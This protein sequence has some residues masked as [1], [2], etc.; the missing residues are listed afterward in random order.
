MTALAAAPDTALRR[1]AVRAVLAPSVHNTQPWRLRLTE[2]RLELHADRARQL[3]V[4]DPT[5]RQLLV[6]CGCALM[7]AR[8]A[9]AG[10]GQNVQVRRNPHPMHGDLLAALTP[11]EGPADEVLAALDPVL[12]VRQTNRRQFNDERVP[13]SVISALQKAAEAEQAFLHIVTDPQERTAVAN[14]SRRADHI[15]NV[16]PAYRAELRAWTSNEPARGDGVPAHAVPQPNRNATDEV[17]IRNFDSHGAGGLPA[18]TGSS[19][20]QALVLLCTADDS[21]SDWLRAGEALERVWLEITRHGYQASPLTQITEVPSVRA[22]LR[23]ELRLAG[24]PHVLLRIGR[25]PA[26]PPTRRRRLVEVLI[27]ES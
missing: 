23:D 12:E 9:L 16:N 27:D 24:Y 25:A 26:T 8:V 13:D 5:S 7:N 15:E 6:S 3:L 18:A 4:L 21:P 19:Q 10:A 2:D 14:L 1:A 11:A 20:G 17:Q 22:E